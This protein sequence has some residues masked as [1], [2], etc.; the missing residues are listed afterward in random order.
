MAKRLLPS[1]NRVLVEK[2]VQPKKTAGG[3]LVPETSKQIRLMSF[4][5]LLPQRLPQLIRQVEQDVE[6]VIH[7]LQP[8]P[9]GIVEHKFTD[10]EILEARATVKR[11]VDNWRRNW[12]LE[13]NVSR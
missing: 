6:T 1:L 4:L 13:R 3:I 7:V 5:R 9:I 8:G 11:A 2:L 10:A 12:T